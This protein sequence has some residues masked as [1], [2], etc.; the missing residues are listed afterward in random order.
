MNWFAAEM[1]CHTLHSD[2]AFQPAELA[3]HAKRFGLSGFCLTDHNTVS[4]AGETVRAAEKQGLCCLPG[5]EWTTYR[6]HMLIQGCTSCLDWEDTTPDGLE[7]VLKKIRASGG[8]AGPAHPFRPGNPFCTGCFWE[9]RVK[10]W[11][12]FHFYE[13][14]SGDD[15]AG[16]FYNERALRHW[17]GLLDEGYR[18]APTS[19]IDWHRPLR[20]GAVYAATWLG[21]SGESLTREGMRQALAGRHTAVTT[22]PLPLAELSAEGKTFVPGGLV[23]VGGGEVSLRLGADL[24][25]RREQWGSWGI[26]PAQWRLVGPGGMVLAQLPFRPGEWL[27]LSLSMPRW[28][29]A[30]LHGQVK[31]ED[32]LIALTSPFFR[33]D[34]V[35]KEPE[36]K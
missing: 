35:R 9:Y 32:A 31:G 30:E 5:V 27:E 12:L 16:K 10:D 7:T 28:L 17:T 13:V 19:G 26:S 29:R 23:P 18:L 11:S 8:F 3:A 22:G 4:A 25:A 20:E 14:L 6:G 24:D 33:Q 34:A 15:P 36:G 2:G 21:C 1:H